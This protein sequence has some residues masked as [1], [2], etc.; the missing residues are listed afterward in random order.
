ML[1]T[2]DPPTVIKI[3]IDSATENESASTLLKDITS[4]SDNET[5][6]VAPRVVEKAGE[7]VNQKVSVT[8][9]PKAN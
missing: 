9:L 4:D 5:V 8:P 2:L 6:S 3:L 7:S 1:R